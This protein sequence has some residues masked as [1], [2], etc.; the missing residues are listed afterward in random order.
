MVRKVD[1]LTRYIEDQLVK[2]NLRDR[3]NVIYVS[4]HGMDSVQSPNFINI[5]SYLENG[6]YQCYGSSP[7]MQIVPQDGKSKTSERNERHNEN[8]SIFDERFK[9]HTMSH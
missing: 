9:V 6:T 7:V 5:S 4:D 8:V 2:E 1:D 3:T